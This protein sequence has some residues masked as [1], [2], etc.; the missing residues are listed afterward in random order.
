MFE[1]YQ[2]LAFPKTF[3]LLRLWFYLHCFFARSLL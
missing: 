1:Q 3:D 2:N